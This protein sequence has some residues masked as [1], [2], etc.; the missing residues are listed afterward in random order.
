MTGASGELVGLLCLA[1]RGK[2]VT[3][4]EHG[5]MEAIAGH[6]SIALENTRLFTRMEQASRH[7]MEIFDALSDFIVVHDEAHNILRVNRSL[8]DFIGVPPAE[9]VGVNM[10]ALEALATSAPHSCPFCRSGDGNDDYVYPV[11]ERTYLVS[12][13]R[14]HGA[15]TE[16]CKRFTS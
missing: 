1:D 4:E 6:A 12:T 5:L 14:I 9:L 15:S 16:T 11:M 7:W 2:P 10:R 13:S 8:A 3:E